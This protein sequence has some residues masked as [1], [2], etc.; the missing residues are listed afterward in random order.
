[1][2]QDMNDSRRVI[3][4]IME[5][6]IDIFELKNTVYEIKCVRLFLTARRIKAEE[7]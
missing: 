5:I 7:K 3:K 6:R 1:M 2:V 4:Q